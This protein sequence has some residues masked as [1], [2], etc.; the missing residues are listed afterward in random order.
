MATQIVLV[1]SESGEL[2]LDKSALTNL[3]S[4][5]ENKKLLIVSCVGALRGGKSTLLSWFVRRSSQGSDDDDPVFPTAW[6]RTP[7]TSGIWGRVVERDD[8]SAWL[9][10]DTQGMFDGSLDITTTSHLF[11]VRSVFKHWA[12]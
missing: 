3:L 11:G 9:F 6:G 8:K 4:P 10:L 7:C 12:F 2:S 5:V 1:N